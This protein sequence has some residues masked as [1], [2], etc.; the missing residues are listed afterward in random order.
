M[1]RAEA[2]AQGTV[3]TLPREAEMGPGVRSWKRNPRTYP[4]PTPGFAS[5][6][7]HSICGMRSGIQTSP[8]THP[9]RSPPLPPALGL[10]LCPS[11]PGTDLDLGVLVPWGG[12]EALA[13]PQHLHSV[14]VLSNL[15]RHS[16][17]RW[18]WEEAGASR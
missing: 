10:A 3:E 12:R 11:G 13:Q 6:G 9:T 17:Q 15:L 1:Q 4:P 2:A 16:T 5:T 8:L 18:G 14:P 7:E